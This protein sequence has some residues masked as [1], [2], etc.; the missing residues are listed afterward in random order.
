MYTPVVAVN[1]GDSHDET[2]QSSFTKKAMIIQ[3]YIQ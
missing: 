2:Y 3:L 1:N